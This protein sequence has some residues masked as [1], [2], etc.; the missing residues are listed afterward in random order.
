MRN[1]KGFYVI[2]IKIIAI[3]AALIHLYAAGFGIFP[4]RIMRSMHLMFLLPIC[5]MLFPANKKSSNE[6]P[7]LFD[8]LLAVISVIVGLYIMINYKYLETRWVLASPVLPIEVILGIINIL[9]ILE[10]VRRAVT[11]AMTIVASFFL[12]YLYIGP[13]LPGIF[14]H[15]GYSI[16]R[17]AE[18]MY[19]A[20]DNGIY[21]LFTGISSTYV[22]VFVIFC[23]FV[24]EGGAGQ[25]FNDLASA[26]TGSKIGGPAKVAVISS[27]LFGM[28][29]GLGVANVYATGS[30]TIPCMKKIGYRPQFAAAVEGAASTG[31]QYMPP[32]MGVAAFIMAEMIGVPYIKIAIAAFI[33]AT[34][35]YF[36]VFLAVHFEALKEGL[37]G[38][39]KKDIPSIKQGIK[40]VY[41]FFPV[42]VVIYFLVKGYSPLMA[43]LTGIITIVPISFF[44]KETSMGLKKI[45]NALEK[46]VINTAMIAVASACAGIIVSVLI[47][48]GLALSFGSIF[49]HLTGGMLLPTLFFTMILC[50]ILGMGLPTTAAYIISATLGAPI[51]IRMGVPILASHLFCFYF[52]II[53]ELTPPVAIVAYAAASIA[54]SDPIKTGFESTKV[55]VAAFLIP[56]VFVYDKALLMQGSFLEIFISTVS[57]FIAAY[58]LICGVRGHFINNKKVG[59]I[60]RIVFIIYALLL[61]FLQRRFK[62]ILLSLLM[63]IIIIYYFIMRS[64]NKKIFIE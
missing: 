36:C 31:G 45:L 47:N 42:V 23:S 44:S 38:L 16:T 60:S 26:L 1:I 24:L 39:P 40:R 64:K 15:S 28:M 25:M 37:K 3:S 53:S 22:I 30:F 8:L 4:L 9:L 41:L 6:K 61:F 5:F 21:G 48:S 52:A 34:L 14:Y 11:P 10:A 57:A 12:L 17:I 7:T 50:I 18:L 19:L 54:G 13:I 27:G 35:Y 59:V 43:G 29:S 33:S 58:F 20:D 46:G 63:I 2:F 51:L 56:Y 62:V 49:M 55:A 32:V